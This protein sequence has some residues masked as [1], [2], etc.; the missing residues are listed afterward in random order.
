MPREMTIFGINMPEGSFTFGYFW[1]D[2]PYNIYHWLDPKWNTLAYYV[3]VSDRTSI[4]ATVISWRDLVIDVLIIP[5][6]EVS[7]LDED[8]LPNNIPAPVAR[9][10]ECTSA[11]VVRYAAKLVTEIDQ[12]SRAWSKVLPSL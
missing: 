1:E 6:G 9:R 4:S 3:N 8:E 7:V 2:R 10:L 11:H 5:G 12:A